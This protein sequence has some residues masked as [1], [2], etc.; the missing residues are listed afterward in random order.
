MA[1][2]GHYRYRRNRARVIR[3]TTVCEL[4]GGD[5]YPDLPWPHPLSTTA[6]HIVPVSEGGHNN[7][8]LRA[9]H[10]QCNRNRWQL[11][12]TNRHGRAW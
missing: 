3:N 8:A 1:R 2:T 5:L 7:S 12:Q 11:Q 10:N 4:C 6:D 9:V